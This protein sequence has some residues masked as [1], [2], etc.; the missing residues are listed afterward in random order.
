MRAWTQ[1][2]T[3]DQEIAWYDRQIAAHAGHDGAAK[4]CM[5][6]CGVGPLTASAA[7][8]TIVNANRF[9]NGRQM[10]LAWSRAASQ[11]ITSIERYVARYN[12]HNRPFVWTATADSILQK[13]ARLCKVVSGTQH[14]RP[15]IVSSTP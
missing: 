9:K 15:M 10:G 3:L 7:V 14:V 13:V 4:R 1:W 8:A 5:D 2:R 6:M 12:Q 11:L